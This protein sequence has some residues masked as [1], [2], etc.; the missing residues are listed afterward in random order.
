MRHFEYEITKHPAEDFSH[1]TYFCSE[2]GE[3][4]IEEVPHEQANRLEEI[5]NKRGI[6][7][8]ELV[9]IGFGKDGIIAIWKRDK[10]D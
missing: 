6:D 9:Q 2:T 4:S 5:L 8:W 7:G 1:L 10:G 3:C